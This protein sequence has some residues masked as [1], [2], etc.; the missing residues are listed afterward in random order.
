MSSIALKIPNEWTPLPHQ[1]Q[2]YRSLGYGNAP[3]ASVVFNVLD[4]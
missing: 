3:D 4:L 2:L 1:E